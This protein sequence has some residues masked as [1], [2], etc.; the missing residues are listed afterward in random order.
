MWFKQISFYPLNLEKLPE[1]ETL[2]AKLGE[3]EFAPCMGLDWFSEGF[4]APVSFSPETVFPA[5][6]TWRV[7]LKKEEKVLPAGVIR[8]ILDERVAEI[9]ENEG[10][11]VGRKE[12]QELK[13]QITDDLLP[14]AFTRSSR[15]EAVFDTRN[16]FLLVNS[17]SPNKADNLLTKLREA[18]GGLE[19]GLPNTKQSPA[20]LMTDWL[21]RGACEGGFE[22]DSDCE[23]KGSGD[24]AAT[25]K[26][27]K[28]DLT[29]DEVVQHVK[30]GKTVTQLGLVW[31][32]QIAFVLTQDFTLKRIQYLDVLQEEAE[33][34][35]DDAA[36]LT[37][38]SQ[39]LM[40]DALSTLLQELVAYLG[41]WQD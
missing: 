16:G 23:L 13:E 36:S 30:N 2:A 15:C 38:A 33:S 8:D 12:K 7:A 28:Q 41:G 5:D 19:A 9:Q 29:A 35:G 22:L 20:S 14:R 34:H 37:F 6:Y 21:L 11:N 4:A 10:R 40:T 31:R 1:L 25:V 24:V 27:S 26:V 39:I 32:E 3:A 18:L 17:A